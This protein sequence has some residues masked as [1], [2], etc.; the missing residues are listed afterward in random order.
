MIPEASPPIP[1]SSSEQS[2]PSETSPRILGAPDDI[3]AR[4]GRS[5]LRQRDDVADVD[6]LCTADHGIGCLSRGHFTEG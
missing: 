2:I 6:V 1:S 3:S 5:D 4:Q